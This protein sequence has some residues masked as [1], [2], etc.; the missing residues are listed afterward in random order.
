M[1]EFRGIDVS[2]YQ[3][4]IDW[5]RVKSDGIEFAM[6][7]CGYGRFSS[8]KDSRFEEN[9]RNAKSAGVNVGAYFFSYAVTV[10]NARLEAE[11]C[12]SFIRGKK[13]EYPIAL[14]IETPAQQRLSREEASAIADTFCS[15]LE[16]NG[17]YVCIYSNLYFLNNELTADVLRRYDVWLAQWASAPTYSGNFGMWQ[18]SSTGSVSGINGAV[19]RDI[20]YKDYPSIMLRNS[21]NG[22][23]S[24]DTAP[25]PPIIYPGR[26]LT[27]SGTPIYSS[28]TSSRVSARV[29]GTYYI[30]SDQTVNG[31]VRITNRS[32]LVGRRP[33]ALFVTGWINTSAIV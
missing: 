18:Y 27:L 21:L 1:A 15:I 5:Q 9:Y 26:T 24:E 7:R 12:L 29:N 2:E 8:Q 13:F 3:G 30:Y 22:F 23:T 4:A 17:Y 32:S 10:E 19:D 6:L 16:R 11:N 31:R 28:S 14:D 20:S 25:T 33:A